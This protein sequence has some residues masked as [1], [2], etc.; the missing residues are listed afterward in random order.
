M[1]EANSEDNAITYEDFMNLA[2]KFQAL[3]FPAGI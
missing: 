1:D 2:K 3:F